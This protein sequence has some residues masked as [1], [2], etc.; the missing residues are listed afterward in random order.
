MLRFLAYIVKFGLKSSVFVDYDL[1]IKVF[2]R[3]QQENK[4]KKEDRNT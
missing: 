4:K 2:L 3:I 1:N